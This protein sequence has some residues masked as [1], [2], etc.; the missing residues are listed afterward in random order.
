MK[1]KKECNNGIKF[2]INNLMVIFVQDEEPA[3]VSGDSMNG[4]EDDS[5]SPIKPAVIAFSIFFSFLKILSEFR[6]NALTLYLY[7]INVLHQF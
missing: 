6:V 4:F 3:E 5:E 7:D 1:Q 2:V